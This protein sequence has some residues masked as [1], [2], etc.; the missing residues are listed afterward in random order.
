MKI[1]TET[2]EATSMEADTE[3]IGGLGLQQQS[4]SFNEERVAVARTEEMEEKKEPKINKNNIENRSEAKLNTKTEKA[5]SMGAD[6]E[7][8]GELGLQQHVDKWGI[9]A[10]Y[11]EDNRLMEGTKL[12]KGT[13]CG[14]RIIIDG[15]EGW[16]PNDLEDEDTM[17]DEKLMQQQSFQSFQRRKKDLN[18]VGATDTIGATEEDKNNIINNDGE[19]DGQELELEEGEIKEDEGKTTET[20]VSSD[21]DRCDMDDKTTSRRSTRKE[22]KAEG[23]KGGR[24]T[25]KLG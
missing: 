3:V 8:I 7:A 2:K 20:S 16:D 13:I 24:R 10:T 23:E 12:Y 5:T 1:N 4:E 17:D 25:K 18:T 21:E 22:K 6:T 11:T 15:L 9:T 19:Q 14:Q